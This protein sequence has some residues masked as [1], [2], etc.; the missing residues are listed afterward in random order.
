MEYE[1]ESASHITKEENVRKHTGSL[2]LAKRRGG[3]LSVNC[4]ITRTVKL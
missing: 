3:M 4:S 1:K 2:N